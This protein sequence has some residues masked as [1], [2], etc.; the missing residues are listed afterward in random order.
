MVLSAIFFGYQVTYVV[1]DCW[2]SEMSRPTSQAPT[3]PATPIAVVRN[4]V[5]I[6]GRKIIRVVIE[7]YRSADEG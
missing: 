5:K 6:E 7:D 1:G 2:P 3:K 4:A